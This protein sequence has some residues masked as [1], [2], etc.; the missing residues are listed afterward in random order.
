LLLLWPAASQDASG[1]LA[2]ELGLS[3]ERHGR[4]KPEKGASARRSLMAALYLAATFV[5]LLAA[6]RAEAREA[7]HASLVID[8][9]SGAVLHAQAADEPRYPASLTKMMTLYM[10]FELIDMGRLSYSAKI[11]VSEA[12]AAASPS[13]LD[14]EP[15]SEIQLIDAMRALVTKSAND[16]AIAVAEHIGGTEA[17]FARLMTEKAR[18]IGMPN[19]TFRNASGLPDPGQV[20]TARDMATLALRLQ[21]DFPR[22]YPL[23]SLRSFTYKGDSY[24]NHNTLLFSYQGTDGIKTGYTR[25]SGFNLVANVR[26]DGRHV[27]GVIFGGS[28]A[29]SR[30]AQLRALLTRALARATTRKSRKP[31]MAAAPRPAPRPP[32]QTVA[33]APSPVPATVKAPLD[34]KIRLAELAPQTAAAPAD[35]P[36]AAPPRAPAVAIDIARVRPVLV[37]PRALADRDASATVAGSAEGATSGA[38]RAAAARGDVNADRANP[39]DI[40]ARVEAPHAEAATAQA[41]T[42]PPSNFEELLASLAGNVAANAASPAQPTSSTNPA[43][44]PPVA[45][46][47]FPVAPGARPSSLQEQAANLAQ[48]LPSTISSPAT[49]VRVARAEPAASP[50]IPRR[51]VASYRIQVGA[52]ATNAEAEARL[53]LVRQRASELVSNRPSEVEPVQKGERQFH[54]ARFSGFDASGA[55]AACA[56]LKR[57]QIECL[58][59]SAE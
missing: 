12:A 18:R 54:R 58:V 13:K 11:K 21:D 53:A 10:A 9:N 6:T 39:N 34:G 52:F 31:V 36:A 30:N 59:T 38:P 55:A 40:P 29:A 56:T 42:R 19:T 24:R 4:S 27:V 48:G 2:T 57:R 3:D 49:P 22:H 44:R 20:T 23:F 37:A 14:L 50:G 26:R 17:N 16:M 33:A 47:P 45:A 15:G 28:S 8:G 32:R 41:G 51:P 35:D 25:A 1:T 46:T 7:R 5:V 43:A